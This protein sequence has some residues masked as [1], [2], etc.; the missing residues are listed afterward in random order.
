MKN[1]KPVNPEI[2]EDE[3]RDIIERQVLNEVV[4]PMNRQIDRSDFAYHARTDRLSHVAKMRRPAAVVINRE[5]HPASAC[6]AYKP[7]PGIQIQHKW[8]LTEDVFSRCDGRFNDGQPLLRVSCN[9]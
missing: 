9:I 6:H 7:V 8:F 2:K 1:I 5:F 4:I 3:L